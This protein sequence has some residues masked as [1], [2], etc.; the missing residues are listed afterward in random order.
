M[1]NFK[2]AFALVMAF[3]TMLSVSSCN[4]D[5]SGN[6]NGTGGSSRMT[7]RMTDAPGDFDEVNIEVTDVQIKST[8]ENGDQGWVSIGNVSAGVYN[9]MDLTGGL[10]AMLADNDVPSGH[11]G[12]I[13]LVLGDD[14][15]VVKNGVSYTLNTPSAQQSGLKLHVNQ[16]LEA[17]ISYDFLI[18]FDVAQSVVS[19]GTSGNYNLHPVLR[20]TTEANSGSI[21]GQV[22]PGPYQV[23]ASVTVGT[24]VISTYANNLGQFVLHGVPAGSYSLTLTTN[25]SVS[26]TPITVEN[27]VVVNGA[28]TNLGNI[29]L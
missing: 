28:V 18:D 3:T 27:V 10:T 19:A 1:K 4:G 22:I 23:L 29:S 2:I 25:S 12:Q 21:R 14:N 15:N 26:T 13:R 16:E 17:D 8:S 5:D 20:V 6:N 11:L 24:Q 9:L 7:V